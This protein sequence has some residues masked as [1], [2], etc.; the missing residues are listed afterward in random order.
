MG[1]SKYPSA[2]LLSLSVSDETSSTLGSSLAT[3]ETLFLLISESRVAVSNYDSLASRFISFFCLTIFLFCY[4]L[5]N[6][7]TRVAIYEIIRM[8]V[9]AKNKIRL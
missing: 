9:V 3:S 7:K 8:Y 1:G 6:P 4:D 2:L 5:T